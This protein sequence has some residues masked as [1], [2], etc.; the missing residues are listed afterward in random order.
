[1]NPKAAF[2]LR[3]EYNVFLSYDF[4]LITPELGNLK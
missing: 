2:L 4:K 1:L 3:K